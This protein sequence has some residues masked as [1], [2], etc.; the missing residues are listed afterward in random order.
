MNDY[1]LDPE[2]G[3]QRIRRM[4]A[5]GAEWC[6]VLVEESSTWRLVCEDRK[7]NVST[8]SRLG[9]SVYAI[10]SGKSFH[11]CCDGTNP[12]SIDRITEAICVSLKREG[13]TSRSLDTAPFELETDPVQRVV[14][15]LDEVSLERKLAA[16]IEADTVARD[17]HEAAHQ[18]TVSYVDG[19]RNALI[20]T[21]KGKIVR[22]TRSMVEMIV[23]VFLK[24]NGELLASTSSFGKLAGFEGLKQP[25][26]HPDYLAREAV[27]KAAVLIDAKPSPEGQM[28]VV[29]APGSSGVL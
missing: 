4:M 29:F 23:Q 5:A 28:P 6:E 1:L 7:T 15:P 21:S 16:V 10:V 18:V 22:D 27:R 11:C 19:V 9:V 13:G 24:V 25:K 2:F 26:C 17:S 14:E 8:L 3:F 20:L 12:S